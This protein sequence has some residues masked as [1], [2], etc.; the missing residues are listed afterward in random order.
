VSIDLLG[1]FLIFV[2]AGAM[3]AALPFFG[4]QSTPVRLRLALGAVLAF[5]VMPSVP[6]VETAGLAFVGVLKLVFVEAGAGLLLGFVCR[7]LFFAVD[8]AGSLVS[9]EIGLALAPNFNPLSA[10]QVTAPGMMLTWLA[11]MLMLT[12]D[13]HHWILLGFQRSYELVP[14]GGARLGEALF[15]DLAGRTGGIFLVAVQMTAPVM[16]VS[17]LITLIFSV[18]GRA[19]PQMNV[20]AESFPVRTLAGLVVFGLSLTLMATHVAN[21]LRRLP[22]EMLRVAQLLGG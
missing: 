19:V 12:L 14:V 13:L 16:A 3:L 6:A 9:T 2:R 18:L 15:N 4:G 22:E 1:W 11:L 20:F 10:T 7:F 8:L 5:L 21:H 17:F